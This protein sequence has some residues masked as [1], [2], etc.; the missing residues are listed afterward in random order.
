[1][2]RPKKEEGAPDG[3][4]RLVSAFWQ[5]LEQYRLHELT[6]GVV[7]ANAHCSR[8]T[9]YHH[10]ANMDDLASAAVEDELFGKDNVS[11][12]VFNLATGLD[13]GVLLRIASS[14]RMQRLLLVMKRGGMDMVDAKVKSVLMDMWQS[15]LCP[16]G[17]KISNDARFIIEY[18]VSGMLRILFVKACADSEGA[19]LEFPRDFAQK[20]ASFTIAQLSEAQGMPK[21][22]IL[23][24]LEAFGAA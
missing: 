5:L 10:F 9:F 15:V 2:A 23:Q 6:V 21:E 13:E 1:M 19:S 3:R 17:S 4:K 16:D 7:C 22:E 12:E 24:R 20:A 8:G 11:F 18:A 14:D